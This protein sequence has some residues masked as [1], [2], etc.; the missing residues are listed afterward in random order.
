MVS[1]LKHVRIILSQNGD[2]VT[3]LPD[4][5]TRLLLVGIAKVDSIELETT[6]MIT[7]KKADTF[8]R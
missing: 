2:R 6:M 1:Q 4:N 3:L 8:D 7:N 5:Q